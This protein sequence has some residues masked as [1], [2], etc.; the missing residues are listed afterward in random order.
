MAISG[1]FVDMH[2][3]D[4]KVVC[5][6]DHHLLLVLPPHQGATGDSIVI[7]INIEHV[8]LSTAILALDQVRDT[9]LPF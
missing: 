5:F 9:L 4:W 7:Y 8:I 3:Q 2:R 1:S 6:E